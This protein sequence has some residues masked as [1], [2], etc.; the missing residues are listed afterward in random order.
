[1]LPKD[2]RSTTP[3]QAIVLLSKPKCPQEN[4]EFIGIWKI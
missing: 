1:M 4:G 2:R 3:K